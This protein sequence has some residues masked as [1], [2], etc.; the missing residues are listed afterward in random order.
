LI[1]GKMF[2]FH[3]N[4]MREKTLLMLWGETLPAISGSEL[5]PRCVIPQTLTARPSSN[6]FARVRDGGSRLSWFLPLA[7][8]ARGCI[9]SGK[10]GLFSR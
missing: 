2:P 3:T 6:A 4:I 8:A 7:R 9:G 10:F 1:S 5:P